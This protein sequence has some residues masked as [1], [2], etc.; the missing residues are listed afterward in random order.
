[1]AATGPRTP[2]PE[3]GVGIP[4]PSWSLGQLLLAI[5]VVIV[6]LLVLGGIIYAFDPDG[7]SEAALLAGQAIVAFVLI[8]T[9]VAFAAQG[10]AGRPLERLGLRRFKL[11]GLGLALAAYGSYIFFGVIYSVFV[12]P[13]QQD[14]T[15]DLGVDESTLAA[16]AGAI[17]I[18]V[19]APISE[20][21]FFRGFMFGALRTRLSLW[22]AAAISASVFALLHLSSGDLSIVPPL[23]VLG[24]LLAWLYEYSGS[25][26]PPIALHMLNNA[27][28]FTVI[29]VT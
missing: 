25:L 22:P 17:L 7:E 10:A 18:V 19:F 8:G 16:I 4:T 15:T 21:I 24:L 5:P 13:E 1:V 29:M 12:Q 28:A 2:S 14:I 23:A 11:S 26:G 3:E 20:E 27:I 6:G 9:A